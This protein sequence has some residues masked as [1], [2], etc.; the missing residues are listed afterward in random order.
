MP[1]LT[2]YPLFALTALVFIYLSEHEDTW[3]LAEA[4]QTTTPCNRCDY[5]VWEYETDGRKLGIKPGDTICLSAAKKYSRLLLKNIEGTA[6]NPVVITNCGG[7]A[8]VYSS[9]GF[10]VKFENSKHFRLTGNGGPEK[11]GIKISTEKGFYL[12]MEKL[13]TDFEIA[14]VEIAGTTE[15]G[16]GSNAGFAGIGVKTSPYQN[17]E[18]FADS[19]RKAWVMQ[20][21]SIHDNYIHDTGGEGLYIGH[22][23]YNGRKEKQCDFVTYAHSIKGLRVFDNLI[24]NVGYDGIQIKNADEDVEVY[25]NV[26][27]NYGTKNHPAHNEGL[28]IG[29]GTTGRFYGNIIDTGTGNGCQIQ[30]IGNIDIYNNVFLNSGE[31][32]M[33]AAHGP[34]VLRLKDAYF[35]ISHNTIYNSAKAGFVFFNNDGGPKIFTNNKVVLAGT[36]NK[37][38]AA[39]EMKNN[40]F[41]NE[42][43]EVADVLKAIESLRQGGR[44]N[45]SNRV[46]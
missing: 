33:Y 37:K 18:L 20:N 14:Q 8:V 6:D 26:V 17:C 21:V 40:L 1:L 31:N 11:Y 4:L 12:T 2:K 19:T 9:T 39:V 15:K 25:N 41:S 22:G 16:L 34:Q 35:N 23:F 10:G 30:G 3:P 29:E 27:N 32:G 28:F 43:T 5:V 36:L 38:G 46:K 7:T 24:E 45:F 13:T 44:V 42:A